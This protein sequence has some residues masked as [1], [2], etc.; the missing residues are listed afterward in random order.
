MGTTIRGA[1]PLIVL[2]FGIVAGACGTKPAAE[3][4]PQPRSRE[5]A[6]SRHPLSSARASASSASTPSATSSSGPTRCACT[7]SSRRASTRRRR[8]RSGSRWTPTRCR[9]ASSRQ[10]DLKSPATT[11]ALLKL[12]AVVG[13]QATVDAEQPHH[14]GSASPARSAT[15]PSTTR[16]CPA[17]ASG[18]DGWPNRDLNVG[19]IIALVA[20]AARGQE[21]GLQV[22]G[23]PA[24]TTR[25][26]T[27]T[28]RARR[29]SSRPRTG[30]P[31]SRTRPTP[32][33]ARSRTGT[34]TS[35]SR[36]WAGRATSP[37]RGSGIDVKHSPDLVTPKLPALRAYQHS[38]PAPPPPAGSFDRGRRDAG[39]A[40]FDRTLREL[41]R[42]RLRHRQQR[43]QAARAGGDR[44]GRRVRGAHGEQGVPH[45]AAARRCGSTRRTST[46]AARRRSPTSSRTTTGSASSASPRS[47][48]GIWSST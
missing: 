30:W 1:A 45:H 38:L 8:S 47:S 21:G 16:S 31:R 7:R 32:R 48:S 26:S 36:R 14:A 24:S 23:A 18:M 42:R 9:P 46:T 37:T 40:V 11:V 20:G 3:A 35:R 22:A 12:N 15:P 29:S 2:S 5:P 33:R 25:A 13:L 41:P 27:R 34:P 17:S 19:A 4:S 10:V 39:A 6:R 43:R 28:A 44:H